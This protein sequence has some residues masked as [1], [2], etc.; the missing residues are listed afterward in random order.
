MKIDI[1]ASDG[2]PPD[3]AKLQTTN[4]WVQFSKASGEKKVLHQFD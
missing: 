3:H 1:G 4:E 2:P